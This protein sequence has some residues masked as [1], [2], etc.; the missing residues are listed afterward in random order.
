[1]TTNSVGV[2][3]KR[4]WYELLADETSMPASTV[5]LVDPG[6]VHWGWTATTEGWRQDS[7]RPRPLSCSRCR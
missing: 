6:V 4:S 5:C 2:N 3:H 7:A 1:M